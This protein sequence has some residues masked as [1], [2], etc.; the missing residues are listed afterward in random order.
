MAVEVSRFKVAALLFLVL[1][2]PVVS[3]QGQDWDFKMTVDTDLN[4]SEVFTS[5]GDEFRVRTGDF[6]FDYGYDVS[7]NVSVEDD[8]VNSSSELSGLT[9]DALLKFKE[10]GGI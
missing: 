5:E 1:L 9:G 8:L 10:R 7:S 4:S 6:S 2:A 3:A